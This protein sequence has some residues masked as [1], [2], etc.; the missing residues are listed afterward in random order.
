MP[1][2]SITPTTSFSY[3]TIASAITTATTNSSTP[4]HMKPINFPITFGVIITLSI[5]GL[6]AALV[7]ISCNSFRWTHCLGSS[8]ESNEKPSDIEKQAKNDPV[9][10]SP[11]S[12]V[13][14]A[15]NLASIIVMAGRDGYILSSNRETQPTIS[16]PQQSELA[17]QQ[18][19]E[20]LYGIRS[21]RISGSS[22]SL[23]LR[24]YVSGPTPQTDAFLGMARNTS[25]SRLSTGSSNY[26]PEPNT[27]EDGDA[28]AVGIV[29]QEEFDPIEWEM[30]K[31]SWAAKVVESNGPPTPKMKFSPSISVESKLYS[32]IDDNRG[33]LSPA[34]QKALSVHELK[35]KTNG[36]V[37][38]TDGGSRAST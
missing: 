4:S 15:L 10:M 7:I 24:E 29:S 9:E 34:T 20:G 11:R 12:G 6:V 28:E 14:L 37:G 1:A 31:G 21:E 26:L 13:R 33:R 23:I 25:T 36:N 17:I 8:A 2:T 35:A 22:I 19:E 16:K 18:L 3:S 30:F 5:L 38:V 32:Y 27:A